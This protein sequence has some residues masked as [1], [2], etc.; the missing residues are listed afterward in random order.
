MGGM[1]LIKSVISSKIC[2]PKGWE[3]MTKGTVRSQEND[4]LNNTCD[5]E[6]KTN[7]EKIKLKTSK[8]CIWCIFLKKNHLFI[9]HLPNLNQQQPQK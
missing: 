7:H 4:L 1:H 8:K 2:A 9:F 6:L 3:A 5:I